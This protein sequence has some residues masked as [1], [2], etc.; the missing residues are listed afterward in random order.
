MKGRYMQ[1]VYMR[2]SQYEENRWSSR[3]AKYEEGIASE[4]R[5]A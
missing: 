5:V 4:N 2:R 1:I 3:Q